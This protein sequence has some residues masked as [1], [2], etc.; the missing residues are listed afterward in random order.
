MS[1]DHHLRRYL[2]HQDINDDEKAGVKGMA[3]KFKS[4]TKP[5]TSVLASFQVV[6]LALCGVMGWTWS[7]LLHWNCRGRCRCNGILHL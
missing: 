2:R 4:T 6:L 3:V 7:F 1:M 5:L